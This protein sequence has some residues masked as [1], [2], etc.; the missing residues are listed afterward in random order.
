MKFIEEENVSKKFKEEYLDGLKKVILQRQEAA[1]HER[2]EY[3]KDILKNQE[4]FRNDLKEMLGWP[5]VNFNENNAF[6]VESEKIYSCSEYTVYRMQ[7][8][9]IDGLKVAGLFFQVD[10]SIKKPLIIVQHG[11]SGT[12]ELISGLYGSTSNYNDML[13]RLLKRNVHIFAP[14][15]LLW[16]EKYGVPFDRKIIDAKLKQTGSSITAIEIFAIMRIID[17]FENSNYISNFGMVGL[18]YGGFYTLYTS[19][20]DT[21]IK[22]AISCSFFN[23]RQSIDWSDWTWFKSLSMFDDAEVSCLV[24][25]RKLYLEMGNRD[26]I[27]D[28]NDSIESFYKLKELCADINTDWVDFKVFDGNHEFYREDEHIE[29]FIEDIIF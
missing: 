25:P 3:F 13:E 17:Y 12:P 21:R 7:F 1:K 2:K 5:L 26:E 15:L 6:N 22:S 18:S 27:F 28:V 16:N 20:I 9:V 10:K 19:A 4:N 23:K 14:Q 29:K 11:G 24:Y 8:E